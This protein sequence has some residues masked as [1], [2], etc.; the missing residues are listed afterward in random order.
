[1]TE[2]PFSEKPPIDGILKDDRI[3]QGLANVGYLASNATFGLIT[4]IAGVGKSSL[5]RLFIDAHKTKSFKLIYMHHTHLKALPFLKILVAA[6]GEIPAYGKERVFNQIQ[7]KI[8]E[9]NLSTIV[10]IDEAHLLESDAFIDLRLLVS[11][12]LDEFDGLKIVLFG[13]P[14]IKKELRRSRHESLLQRISINYHLSPMIQSQT[15]QYI[16]FQLRRVNGS[17]KI[18]EEEVKNDIHKYARGI[19]RIVNKIATACLINAYIENQQKINNGILLKTLND[20]EL[21]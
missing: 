5:I 13:H 1:M 21:N 6:L 3:S 19:P 4:G 8:K 14:D 9:S 20:I 15:R 17:E 18:F 10:L 2:I 12:A 11:S 16:D 7:S